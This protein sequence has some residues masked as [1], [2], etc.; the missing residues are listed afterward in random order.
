MDAIKMKEKLIN[1]LG[2]IQVNS[3]LER[4]LLTGETKPIGDIPKFDSMI[5]PVATTILA[6]EIGTTIPN[7]VNIFI[8]ETTKRSRS[9]D[10]TATFVS[11]LAKMQN[12]TP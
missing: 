1:V 11:E 6:I 9:I 8:D 4:P 12:G 5:W 3:G 7:N 2:D 10:E